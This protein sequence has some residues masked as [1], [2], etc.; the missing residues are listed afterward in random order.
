MSDNVSELIPKG[1]DLDDP[2]LLDKVDVMMRLITNPEYGQLHTGSEGLN[3]VVQATKTIAKDGLGPFLDVEILKAATTTAKLAS[4]TV[5]YTYV[6]LT[7]MQTIPQCTSPAA[8]K[9]NAKQLKDEL[10]KRL[11]SMNP[12]IVERINALEEG[13]EFQAVDFEKLAQD[14]QAKPAEDAAAQQAS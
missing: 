7:V 4:D 12:C 8:R 10:G 5:T 13:T 2:D 14:A 9:K 3:Q 6:L 11:K 1:C